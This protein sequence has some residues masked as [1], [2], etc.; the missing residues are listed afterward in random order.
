MV[1][2]DVIECLDGFLSKILFGLSDL[3][4]LHK[5]MVY[6]P[7]FAQAQS[8]M[9]PESFNE[10]SSCGKGEKSLLAEIGLLKMHYPAPQ[11]VSGATILLLRRRSL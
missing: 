4:I 6:R 5:R 9:Y 7:P 3:S 8:A 10:T 11:M 1:S 2:C